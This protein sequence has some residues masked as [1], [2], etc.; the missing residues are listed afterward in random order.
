MTEHDNTNSGVGFTSSAFTGRVNFDGDDYQL[1]VVGASDKAK[2]K[3]NVFIYNREETYQT[4]LFT[5]DK[6]SDNSH[7]YGGKIE[8]NNGQTY[9]L[10]VWHKKSEKG[11]YYLSVAV[12]N[13]DDKSVMDNTK[14]FAD[15]MLDD[16]N[17]TIPF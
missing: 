2:F 8:L 7:D 12:R 10:N 14:S 17:Q 5:K 16:E 15:T 1:A 6:K 11:K 9:W 13:A 3:F 4:V